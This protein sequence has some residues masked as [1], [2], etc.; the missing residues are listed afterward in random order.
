MG[1]RAE[2]VGKNAVY[3]M[4]RLMLEARADSE[5][6]L[7]FFLLGHSF[8]CRVVCSALNDLQ[9]DI[10]NGTIAMPKAEVTYRVVL[11]EAAFDNDYMEPGDVYAQVPEIAGVRL[12]MTTSQLDKALTEWYPAASKL[13]NLFHKDQQKVALGAG[14]PTA[15]TIAAFETSANISVEPGFKA[16]RVTPLSESLIVADLTPVHQQRVTDGVYNGGLSGSHSDIYFEEVYQMVM[17][18]LFA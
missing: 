17:G 18:F 8:G 9:V 1:Q 14:G 12:L 2:L 11:L 4:L 15:A 16:D 7:R 13:Q 6:G 5:M 3:S 10:A